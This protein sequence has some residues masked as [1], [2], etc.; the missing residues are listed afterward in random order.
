M[1]RKLRFGRRAKREHV[2]WFE[3]VRAALGASAQPWAHIN[4]TYDENVRRHDELMG[5]IQRWRGNP[6]VEPRVPARVCKGEGAAQT[7]WEV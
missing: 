3:M 2:A 6:K 1:T 4:A 5:R 7:C